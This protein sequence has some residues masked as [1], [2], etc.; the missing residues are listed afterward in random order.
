MKDHTRTAALEAFWRGIEK[1]AKTDYMT[2][3]LLES[4]AGKRYD[5][6][7]QDNNPIWTIV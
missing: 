3:V 2:N 4:I 5:I 7:E 6:Y 1:N